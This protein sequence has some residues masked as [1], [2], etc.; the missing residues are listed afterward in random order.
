GRV[1]L[2]YVT[3]G[4]TPYSAANV[5][6]VEAMR[7]DDADKNRLCPPLT[8]TGRTSDIPG[9]ALPGMTGITARLGEPDL[10]AWIESCRLNPAAGAMAKAADPEIS[11][12]LT[13]MITHMGA[14]MENL[15]ARTREAVPA[16]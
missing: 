13:M 2:E 11:A 16:G 4:I 15:T 3:I 5:A 1:N 10:A 8:L 9:L 14:A 12:G 7:E 6:A